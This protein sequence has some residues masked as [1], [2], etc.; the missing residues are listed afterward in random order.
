MLRFL[1]PVA[2]LLLGPTFRSGS[3]RF[4]MNFN[5]LAMCSDIE[6]FGALNANE[7]P[8]RFYKAI[9]NIYH[10][11]KFHFCTD[12]FTIFLFAFT[13]NF[14]TLRFFFAF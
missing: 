9:G 3:E 13:K 10:F 14:N 8:I 4:F 7:M 5:L 6:I 1:P 2:L 11:H 12:I